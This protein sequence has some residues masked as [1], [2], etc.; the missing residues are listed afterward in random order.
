MTET[1][2]PITRQAIAAKDRSGKLTVS[3]KLKTAIDLMLYGNGSPNGPSCRTDAA[4]AA[5]MTDHGLREAFKKPHVK[6]YYNQGLE[7]LR[8]SERA[9]NISALVEVRD[10][11]GNQMA[12]VQAAKALEQLSEEEARR[13]PA[14]GTVTLPGL[15]VVIVN[16]STP[17]EP[18][19]VTPRSSRND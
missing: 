11:A 17:R 15:T 2:K 6:A 5:G 8:Q 9:R 4:K 18:I 1:D 13:S 16:P 3:G 12:R 19:D 7:V 10:K 14:G